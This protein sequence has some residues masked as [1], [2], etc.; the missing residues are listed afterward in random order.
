MAGRDHGLRARQHWRRGAWTRWVM[1][2]GLLRPPTV[3]W[4]HS[5]AALPA[6]L[7]RSR[8]GE[9]ELPASSWRA[10]GFLSAPS[11]WRARAVLA[12][13]CGSSL[14]GQPASAT[15]VL[16]AGQHRE[17]S[18]AWLERF[19]VWEQPPGCKYPFPA[20][21]LPRTSLLLLQAAGACGSGSCKD[22]R[23]RVGPGPAPAPLTASKERDLIF[24]FWLTRIT[25]TL[26]NQQ[27]KQ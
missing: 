10:P 19:R 24:C 3:P 1:E 14:P 26:S 13:G 7:L 5:R 2:P 12:A 4:C 8:A 16:P 23:K 11:L 18:L 20:P 25:C 27:M 21:K 6:N 9:G 15:T 22:V 17:R